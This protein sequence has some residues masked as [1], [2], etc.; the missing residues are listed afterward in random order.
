LKPLLGVN[1]EVVIIA[2]GKLGILEYGFERI[3]LKQPPYPVNCN[4]RGRRIVAKTID[5]FVKLAS[6]LIDQIQAVLEEQRAAST[7]S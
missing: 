4:D 6:Q 5:D 7:T 3:R 1:D 2:T